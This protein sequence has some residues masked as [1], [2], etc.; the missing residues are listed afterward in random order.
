MARHTPYMVVGFSSAAVLTTCTV[1]YSTELCTTLHSIAYRKRGHDNS[2]SII[3]CV[4]NIS[5]P[6]SV[7]IGTRI[8]SIPST[9]IPY[10]YIFCRHDKNYHV[11]IFHKK[12][13]QPYCRVELCPVLYCYVLLCSC[14]VISV[15]Q[16]LAL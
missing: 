1:Y 7:Y 3:W 13:A 12:R 15:P 9:S 5:H 8:P 11:E 4:S 2:L 16:S 14:M 6:K 10:S